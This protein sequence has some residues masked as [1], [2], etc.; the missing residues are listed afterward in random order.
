MG[1]EVVE[2]K[3][4]YGLLK[5]HWLLYGSEVCH[6]FLDFQGK[7]GRLSDPDKFELRFWN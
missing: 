6:N 7:N 5:G 2:L 1:N 3:H 4:L